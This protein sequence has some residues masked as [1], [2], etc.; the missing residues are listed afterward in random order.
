VLNGAVVLMITILL[1]WEKVKKNRGIC[2]YSMQLWQYFCGW[3]TFLIIVNTDTVI[4]AL[5]QPIP[6]RVQ[7]GIEVF[8]PLWTWC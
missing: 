7:Y 4:L 3:F 6:S 5:G 1:W 8:C 2:Y